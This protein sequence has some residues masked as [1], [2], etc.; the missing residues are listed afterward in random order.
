MVVITT[1]IN[2]IFDGVLFKFFIHLYRILMNSMGDIFRTII[3]L[4]KIATQKVGGGNV[5]HDVAHNVVHDKISFAE[6]IKEKVRRNDRITRKDIADEAGVSV[7][8]IEI[9]I[10]EIDNL[11]NLLQL[12]V[13]IF[14]GHFY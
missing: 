3:I 12:S 1:M 8:T 4:K 13:L 6:F 7:K 14:L 9:A 2:K 11:S 5:V 10:K